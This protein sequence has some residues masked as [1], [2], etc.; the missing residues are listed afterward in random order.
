MPLFRKILIANRG[1]I[2]L[3]LLRA[4]RDLAIPAVVV[5]SD[6]DRAARHV[7]LADEAI[8]IGP[9]PA[10]E[11]YLNQAAILDAARCSGA[12]ALHPGY[13]FLAE[14]AGFAR[15]CRDA[16][17]VFIGPSPEAMDCLGDKIAARQ[18]AAR[19]GAPILP[20]ALAPLGS[21]AAA[22]ARAR[23]I[24][25]PVLLKAAG[26]GG[27]KGM[28]LIE[29]DAEL[30]SAYAQVAGEALRA[31]GDDR[32]Y[33][34][35]VLLHPRHIEVQ[36]LAD[37][38]GHYLHLGERECSLQRRHQKIVEESPA[39]GLAPALRE[40]ICQAALAI[41]SSAGYTNA[42]TAEFLLDSS[43]NF[44]FLEMNTRLQV[45]HPVTEMVA[46]LDLVEAQIRIAAGEPLPWLQS[47]LRF[48]GHA[49]ECRIYA[50]DPENDFFPSPGPITRLR[51]P[52]GPGLRE[53]SGIYEGWTVPIEYDPL[54]SKLI[55]W[56]ETRAQAAA[57][58]RRALAEYELEGPRHN[59]AFFR[60]IFA[61]PE[62]LAGR[63]DTGYITRLPRSA[64]AALSASAENPAELARCELAAIAAALS[65][66]EEAEL[67]APSGPPPDSAR[68]GSWRRAARWLG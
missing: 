26:G 13:G 43:G 38:H 59:L 63:Y 68:S 66:A 39:P 23:E 8:R 50:E 49:F 16:G 1:E 25:F 65:A 17:I 5:Y 6:A 35:Q 46:G 60:R 24:G 58:M 45:E 15:A 32:I 7:L 52:S 27:G 10:A 18:V 2:A 51:V 14:N 37:R 54:L 22:R 41:A 64:S 3:R 30:D 9:A 53:D 29:R 36:I 62:F 42:G 21:A 33:L 31:F 47:D 56:G 57:R 44:Y 12:D 40:Q 55:A 4:C 20:G 11:S 34:E 48:R 19:A 61:E 28:R 67:A